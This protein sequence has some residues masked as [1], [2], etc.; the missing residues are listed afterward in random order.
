M[1][2]AAPL[3]PAATFCIG[4]GRA[5]PALQSS[6]A[7][8]PVQVGAFVPA[9]FASLTPCDALLSRIGTADS[10]ETCSS[11]FMVE[12]QVGSGNAV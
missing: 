11:S 12:M 6:A 4:C 9:A 7:T 1:Q 3:C 2:Q 8:S 5:H 10:L